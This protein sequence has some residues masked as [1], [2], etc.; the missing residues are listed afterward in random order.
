[1]TAVQGFIERAVQE[2]YQPP[3][4][5]RLTGEGSGAPMAVSGGFM[6][7]HDLNHCVA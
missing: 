2:S 5:H 3:G 7:L 4:S 6:P 1:M